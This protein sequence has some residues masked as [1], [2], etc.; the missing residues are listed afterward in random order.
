M[1]PHIRIFP[2]SRAEFPTKENL[3]TWLANGLK[4][5]GGQYLLVSRDRVAELP[6][7]SVVLFRYGTDIVG[8]AVVK[9]SLRDF[10][11]TAQNSAT[12]EDQAYESCVRF[13]PTS[14]RVY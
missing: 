12:G 10:P 6:P 7:G 5:R 14:I 4:H 9:E 13:E 11:V 8:E 1:E 2:H 3:T